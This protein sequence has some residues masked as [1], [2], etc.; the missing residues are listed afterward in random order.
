MPQNNQLNEADKLPPNVIR[1]DASLAVVE[2]E[3][4]SGDPPQIVASVSSEVPLPDYVKWN[5][6]Y[7]RVLLSLEH[8]ERAIDRTYIKDGLTIRDGHSGDQIGLIANP[9]VAEGKL[10]G[11]VEFCSGQR[12]QDLARD[13]AKKLRR[14]MSLE[15]LINLDRLEQTG[16]DGETPILT[17]RRWMPTGAALTSNP[18]ADASVGVF[19][20]NTKPTEIPKPPKKEHRDMP[21]ENE[22]H[23]PEKPVSRENETVEIFAIAR[24]FD[25]PNERV[26]KAIRDG[27]SVASFSAFARSYKAEPL[28]PTARQDAD[29][30]V[31]FEQRDLKDYS[32]FR[33]IRAQ[34][35]GERIGNCLEREI[36]DSIAKATGREA[37]GLYVP[38]AVLSRDLT[39][40]GVGGNL[41]AT[42]LLAGEFIDVLRNKTALNR[43]GARMVGGLQGDIA[44]PKQTA[45]TTAYWVAESGAP[46]ESDV[47]LKQLAARPHTVGAFSDV[48]RRMLMQSSISAQALV[49][50]DIVTQLGLAIDKAGIQGTG[51]DGQPKG[52]I[53]AD[54]LNTPTVTA[55]TPTWAQILSYVSD[56]QTDNADL[57][58]MAWLMPPA[59][60]AKL[61]ASTKDSGSGQ[62]ILDAERER[63]AGIRY[64]ASNQAVAKTLMLG[65]WSQLLVLMWGALDL[66]VD[67]YTYSTS[68]TVRVVG[69]QDVD[70]LCRHGEAFAYQTVLS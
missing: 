17:A 38:S 31:K 29:E 30:A 3:A 52:V 44:I 45:G 59:A 47:T 46:T 24:H 12:A 15:A 69:L 4:G 13:C 41:V 67:P 21:A 22:T 37:K 23:A 2:R 36:S 11:V 28:K 50:S 56:I 1:R 61:A 5:G 53:Y 34:I 49:T 68:G 19:R 6:T 26:E 25:V 48:S 57:G 55:G 10:G 51:A 54:G 42:N 18:P 35:P 63:M 60:W 43:L 14:S 39:T 64:V 65:V 16:M 27:E 20:D 40:G 32:L 62:F 70:V 33:A 7:Q 9:V 8:S 66:T 58:D